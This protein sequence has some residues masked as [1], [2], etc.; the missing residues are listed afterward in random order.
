MK[1]KKQ[2]FAIIALTL[3]F[4]FFT[5]GFLA[6]RRGSVNIVTVEPRQPQVRIADTTT[7]PPAQSEMPEIPLAVSPPET[8]GAQTDDVYDAPYHM[9]GSYANDAE[10]LPGLGYE[11]G[12]EQDDEQD[13]IPGAPRGGDH[14][15]ININTATRTELT[16]LHGIGDVLA[17]RIIDYRNRTGGF[18]RIEDIMNVSGIGPARFEAIRDRITV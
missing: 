2:E 1:L 18:S 16:D 9:E 12:T 11:N 3:A 6:G 5:V 13:E 14:R 10:F 7:V 8:P 17:G 15:I 4:V